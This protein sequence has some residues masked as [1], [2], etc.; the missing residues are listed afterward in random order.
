MFT[1]D[2]KTFP[3]QYFDAE[4]GLWYNWHRYYD[5]SIGRYIQSDPIGL[6]GGLNTYSYVSNNPITFIDPTGL[7]G[8]VGDTV[9][10]QVW[11]TRWG[12]R[13][14]NPFYGSYIAPRNV[15]ERGAN[16]A[17]GHALG[18]TTAS[19]FS[20]AVKTG[21]LTSSPVGLALELLFYTG[22]LAECQGL[23]CDYDGNGVG[24][25]DERLGRCSAGGPD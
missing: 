7:D 13:P 9:G 1:T 25:L 24:D 4:S 15:W 3:G 23:N 14:G 12:G 18:K 22:G 2:V 8:V 6:A 20:I 19:A 11:D 10:G 21:E 17:L 5:A 16:A